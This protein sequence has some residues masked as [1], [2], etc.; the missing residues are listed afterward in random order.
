MIPGG[1]SRTSSTINIID[2]QQALV[3][4]LY[5]IPPINVSV[6]ELSTVK[7]ILQISQNLTNETG[8]QFIFVT[9]DLAI[10]KKAY[11]IIWRKP[12]TFKNVFTNFDVIHT[13]MSWL[14]AVE[15]IMNLKD[16]DQVCKKFS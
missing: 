8:Q 4:I 14:G 9:F 10:E 15:K 7:R 13:I 3:P 5:D 12:E 2:Q 16:H 1:K 11:A 6:N